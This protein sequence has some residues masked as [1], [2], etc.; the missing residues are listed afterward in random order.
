[1][2]W[3]DLT[4]R[5]RHDLCCVTIFFILPIRMY[6]VNVHRNIVGMLCETP[7]GAAGT[8]RSARDKLAAVCGYR[9][10]GDKPSVVT[11]E[12]GDAFGNLFRLAEA[13]DR[14]LRNDT[15]ED[16]CRDSQ[17]HFRVDVAGRHAVDGYAFAGVLLC[18]CL[19]VADHPRLR[20]GVIALSYL[21]FL[22]VHG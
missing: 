8:V 14:N 2:Y 1:M 7:R 12:E 10:T 3:G 18:Q 6:L 19:C 4:P 5:P 11:R 20:R 22:A 13:A 21:A 16:L 9:C 15:F 17:Y